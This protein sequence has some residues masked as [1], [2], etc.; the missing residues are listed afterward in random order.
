MAFDA[1]I[2]LFLEAEDP[3]L[4]QDLF[5]EVNEILDAEGLAP[6][7]EPASWEEVFATL[8][9]KKRKKRL[10]SERLGF[11][12]SGKYQQI[13]ELAAYLAVYK[14]PPTLPLE[15]TTR[16]KYE[17]LLDRC[18]CFDH[19]L[20]MT[21]M[22]TALLPRELPRVLRPTQKTKEVYCIA[23]APRLLLECEVLLI[24]CGAL[25]SDDPREEW[26]QEYEYAPKLAEWGITPA[27]LEKPWELFGE[28]LD[29]CHRLMRVAQN[30][31]WSKA[32]AFTN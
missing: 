17:A 28:A 16:E 29:L 1:T 31:L 14:R 23:S 13:E 2:G 24:A 25:Q 5:R 32:L 3:S 6:H 11:Y 18:R 30:V 9:P 27:V 26:R 8:P 10:L 7:K 19:T 15:E 20:A 12:S 4:H 22:G 21:R